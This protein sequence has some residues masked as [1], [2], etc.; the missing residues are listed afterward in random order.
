MPRFPATAAPG[1][2]Q[3]ETPPR[4][5]E[6]AGFFR[7]Q[8]WKTGMLAWLK[9]RRDRRRRAR[10]LYGS[11][12]TQARRE[13]FYASWGVP[14]TNEGRFEMIVLHLSLVLGRL[15][16]EGEPG[17]KLGQALTEVFVVD[18]D[19]GLREMTVGDLAVPRQVKR[20]VATLRERYGVYRAALVASDD[21]PLREAL[22]ARLATSNGAEHLNIDPLCAYIRDTSR[23]LGALS[24]VE[25][26]AGHVGWPR[27]R[28]LAEG[29][30]GPSE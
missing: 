18:V 15:S 11:I 16:G 2:L 13:A 28:A 29:A 7:S 27:P 6:P 30:R 1:E 25:V 17:R 9:Q 14:D 21:G 24:G 22:A 12:V 8:H 5:P 4:A 26:L 3:R 19:D 23:V 10:F 20:A